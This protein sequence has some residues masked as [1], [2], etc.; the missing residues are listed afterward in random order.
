LVIFSH[1]PATHIRRGHTKNLIFAL[2]DEGKTFAVTDMAPATNYTEFRLDRVGE[3][4][5]GEWKV[6]VNLTAES[7]KC[8]YRFI[9]TAET[10]GGVLAVLC[11]DTEAPTNPQ[12]ER[13]LPNVGALRPEVTTIVLDEESDEWTTGDGE[14]FRALLLPFSNEPQ[15]QKKTLPVNA[16]K[17]RLTYYQPGRVEEFKRIDSGCWLNEA[18]NSIDLEVGGIVYLIASVQF[19]GHACTLA[20]PRHSASRYSEDHT[21]LDLL[22]A[23]VYELKVNLTSGDYGEFAETYYF[24]LEVGDQL[25]AQRINPRAPGGC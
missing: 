24:R 3:I 25:N 6:T 7:Y 20:N 22:P 8:D 11:E 21:S 18:Y 12:D 16:L 14:G 19:E 9:L 23:G 10:D 15:R 17:A 1:V 13:M 2:R 4:T 5:A